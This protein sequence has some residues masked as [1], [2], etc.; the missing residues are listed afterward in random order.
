MPIRGSVY[1]DL[2]ANTAGYKFRQIAQ[3]PATIAAVNYQELYI[4]GPALHAVSLTAQ[5]SAAV[6]SDLWLVNFLT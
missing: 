2:Y 1:N 5:P 6:T 3:G 4:T